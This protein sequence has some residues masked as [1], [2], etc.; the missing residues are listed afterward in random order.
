MII[1]RTALC[2]F[3][4]TA[5]IAHASPYCTP[6]PFIQVSLVQASSALIAARGITDIYQNTKEDADGTYVMTDRK[7]ALTGYAVTAVAATI[8]ALTI[9]YCNN[10][11]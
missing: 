5:P 6:L 3:M 4:L 1:P 9:I 10:D 2:A 8:S 11:R 7:K